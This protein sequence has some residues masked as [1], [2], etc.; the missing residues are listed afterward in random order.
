MLQHQQP[1]DYVI[2]TGKTYSVRY[3]VELVAKLHDYNIEWNG[4]GINEKGIDSKTGK[5][6]IEVSS[7][8]YRP[9]E[10]EYLC[11]DSTL[12][13]KTLNWDPKVD[14]NELVKIMVES[15]NNLVKTQSSK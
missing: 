8:Y 2:S 9:T 5:I 10:V 3:F 1:G 14:I 12:A 13:R 4:E 15:D 7:Q 6:L 11:G